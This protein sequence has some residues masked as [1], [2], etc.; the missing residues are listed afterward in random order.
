MRRGEVVLLLLLVGLLAFGWTL[1]RDRLGS[2]EL[3]RRDPIVIPA[4]DVPGP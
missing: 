3:P 4:P 2:A 1:Y